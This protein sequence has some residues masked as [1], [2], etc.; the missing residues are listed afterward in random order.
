MS[1]FAN[2]ILASAALAA[3]A[4]SAAA[5]DASS[6]VFGAYNMTCAANAQKYLSVPLTRPP[7]FSGKVERALAASSEIVASG[8]P[9]FTAGGFVYNAGSQ[10]NRYYLKFTSGEL[11]GA[12]F[13][14]S[15]NSAYS[16]EIETGSSDIAKVAAGDSFEIIPHWTLSTLF[17]NGAGFVKST[18]KT[19]SLTSCTSVG[20]FT[21]Q[22][23]DGS[24]TTP[25]GVL[26]TPVK[27][28]IYRQY[29]KLSTWVEKSSPTVSRNDDIVEP[30]AVLLVK[31]PASAKA[32]ITLCGKVPMCAT[33]VEIARLSEGS[34]QDNYVAVPTCTAVKL[35]ALTAALVES[36]AFEATGENASEPADTVVCCGEGSAE[37]FYM[38][39]SSGGAWECDDA[40]LQTPAGDK[41][42]K[43]CSAL[44]IR[45]SSRGTVEV[46]RIKIYPDYLSK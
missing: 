19:L 1:N 45:K 37:Y 7:A 17:P 22:E 38:A 41:V 16:V 35:S 25:V 34:E 13:D 32:S 2:T 27:T 33:S 5:A 11:E 8:Q 36:G 26:S 12:W 3:C 29:G 9:K 6:Q 15:N 40:K 20:K 21:A 14:I 30:N 44:K 43:A 24:I 23:S 42:L 28:Y 31:Q 46:R 10:T 4:A 18:S 39:S